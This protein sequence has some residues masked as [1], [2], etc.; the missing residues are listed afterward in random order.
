MCIVETLQG[1]WSLKIYSLLK[2]K[3]IFSS[4]PATS[5]EGIT[6]EI[7]LSLF[8]DNMICYGRKLQSIYE[9]LLHL[10]YDVFQLCTM[11]GQSIRINCV[12]RHQQLEFALN[13]MH[14]EQPSNI[15]CFGIN[16]TKYTQDLHD[17]KHKM[18]LKKSRK[19]EI[20]VMILL[21]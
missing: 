21:C 12:S 14:L 4:V 13:K 10:I 9:K 20:N 1:N 2:L 16:L 17:K 3:E 15:K 7:K 6:E 5:H 8:T 19:T 18:L 11:Q